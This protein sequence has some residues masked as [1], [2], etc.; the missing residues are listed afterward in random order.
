MVKTLHVDK[1]IYYLRFVYFHEK[2]LTKL[3]KPGLNPKSLVE[4]LT[5]PWQ[6][7]MRLVERIWRIG[8]K[9][10]C[11]AKVLGTVP[12]EELLI[13]HVLSVSCPTS[14]TDS[15]AEFN[16]SLSIKSYLNCWGLTVY[17]LCQ[18]LLTVRSAHWVYAWEI[19]LSCRSTLSKYNLFLVLLHV[20]DKSLL[21]LS[22]TFHRNSKS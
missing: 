19:K 16:P 6:Q 4:W 2:E 14:H 13:V 5:R 11:L 17:A 18:T 15:D 1:Q 20:I 7:A 12:D 10:H 21:S 3:K 8:K 22:V 9:D